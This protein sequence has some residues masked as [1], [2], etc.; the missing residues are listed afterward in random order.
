M[1]ITTKAIIE[2]VTELVG[3]DVVPLVKYIKDKKNISEFK[4]AEKI[5]QE[6]NQTR[7]QLYRLHGHHLVTYHRK[8][9]R[10]KGWYISYWTF[11]KK[12][13]THVIERIKQTKIEKLK[14]RLAKETK[15]HNSF[16]ICPKFCVR[17]N[18]DIATDFEFRCPECGEMLKQQD[19][20]KTI[21]HLKKQLKKLEA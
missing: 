9:D 20:S 13:V 2:T 3:Q 14:Q 7:N 21:D 19:N 8:K 16:Y 4:I 18:F 10:Q 5:D 6:V 12:R 1:R 15:N 17:L 11:N